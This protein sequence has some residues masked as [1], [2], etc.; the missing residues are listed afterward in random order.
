MHP[1][2]GNKSTKGLLDPIERTSEVL[3]G[4]IMALSFTCSISAAEA[5]REDVRTML[6]GAV[7][8]NIAWG[9]IDAIIFL[10]TSLT[11]RAR[12]IATLRALRQ[13]TDASEA[14]AIITETLPPLVAGTMDE[15]DF[16]AIRRN[17]GGM[18][19]PPPRPRLGKADF[20]AAVGIFFLVFLATFPVVIPF[21]FMRDPIAALRISNAIALV[22]L[23]FA[24]FSLGHHAQHRPLRMG[25]AM[26]LLGSVL[27]MITISPGG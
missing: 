8:C 21:L 4:L 18:S 20:L 15:D 23:F 24:G 2:L 13:A 1:Q 6:L 25:L 19:E 26:M 17:L 3:F 27:V 10:M 22:M 16:E 5:G 9:L 11:E 14:R 12:G 7:G